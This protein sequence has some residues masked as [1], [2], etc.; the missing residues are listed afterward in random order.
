MFNCAWA[1]FSRSF[2]A[3]DTHTSSVSPSSYGWAWVTMHS[4]SCTDTW[5]LWRISF[6]LPAPLAYET[7]RVKTEGA[8]PEGMAPLYFKKDPGG[9]CG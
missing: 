3:E 5:S 4:A 7:Q 9:F 1:P 2:C 8:V 6:G